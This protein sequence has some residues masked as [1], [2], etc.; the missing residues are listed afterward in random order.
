MKKYFK[1]KNPD[2]RKYASRGLNRLALNPNRAGSKSMS[3]NVE[4]QSDTSFSIKR[5]SALVH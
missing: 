4:I 1:Q 2:Y 3:A 5:E